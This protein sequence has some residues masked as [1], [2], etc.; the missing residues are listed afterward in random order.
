[1]RKSMRSRM[2][3]GAAALVG[4]CLTALSAA[5]QQERNVTTS[6]GN[7]DT[8]K[9]T[10]SGNVVL[11]YVYRSREMTAYTD[12]FSGAGTTARSENTFE[13]Y[14]AARLD[15]ELSD[16]VSAQIE[17][18]TKRLDGGTINNWGNATANAIQLREAAVVLNDFFLSDLKAHIGITNWSFDV[19]GKGSAFAFDPRHSQTLNRNLAGG[20]APNTQDLGDAR[21]GLATAVEELESVGA[22]FTYTRNNLTFD[23]VLLPAA[24]EG[25]PIS[26]A[27]GDEAL[28]AID[29][30]YKLDDKGSKV[31]MILAHS[32]LPGAGAVTPGKSHAA[33]TTIGGGASLKGLGEG[34]E[35]YIE[36]YFQ[37]GKA[38][39][40][41]TGDD[42]RANGRAVQLG[43]EYHLQSE[44]QIWF[45]LNFTWMSGDDDTDTADDQ[46]SRF[47]SYENIHDLMIL[48]DQVFGFDWDSN[49]QM[50]K[51]MA[52]MSFSVAGGKNNLEVGL[53]A[54][55]GRTAKEV[56]FS[57]GTETSRKL[58][59][60]IDAK[61]RW[62]LNKQASISFGLA[63]LFSSSI[64]EESMIADGFSSSDAEETT[65][66]YTLGVDLRF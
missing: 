53:I 15:V 17:L 57:A 41:A 23:L 25:G 66:L 5:A 9:V 3:I 61:V 30:W 56:A 42:I 32:R 6:K 33:I 11:D 37:S 64:L 24:I 35:L 21:L 1:M 60:E 59:N 12:S 38:G 39:E 46:A 18:G 7:G 27:T 62:H 10:V 48:E 4:L 40:D 55:F 51:L 19:R 43:G 36:G 65:Y 20:G 13:G 14:V 2:G 44:N 52:G 29:G 45:G 28:Y 22:V 47:V 31:G 8:V 16:K 49:L 26:T 54:G 34:V 50:I 58:G 63:Y